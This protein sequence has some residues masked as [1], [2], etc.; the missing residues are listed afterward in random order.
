[1]RVGLVNMPWYGKDHPGEWGVRAGSRW[2]H[3][4][5]LPVGAAHPR[6]VPFPFLMAIASSS[7]VRLGHEVLL[8]DAVAEGI[9][10][11]DMKAR[12]KAFG[13]ELI[14]AETST[15]SL[16]HDLRLL[17]LIRDAMPGVRLVCGG[18]HPVSL[19]PVSNPIDWARV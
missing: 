7:I 19:V 10:V 17:H 18:T 1:M 8:L 15:P 16:A 2:P 6:Y 14:F 13:P 5:P 4:Q 12:L 3:F 9:T 11:E